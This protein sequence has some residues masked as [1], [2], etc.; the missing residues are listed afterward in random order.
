MSETAKQAVIGHL[1]FLGYQVTEKDFITFTR[2]E[3]RSEV[4]LNIAVNI[5]HGDSIFITHLFGLAVPGEKID[6]Q[7]LEALNRTNARF[8]FTKIFFKENDEK[9]KFP[10]CPIKLYVSTANL[11]YTAR[12]FALAVNALESNT[13]AY[14][15]DLIEFAD[16]INLD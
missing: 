9:E 15:E 5:N 10:S 8:L 1:E 6:Q 7:F 3:A 2:L 11:S 4:R 14:M 16:F 12:D 13:K